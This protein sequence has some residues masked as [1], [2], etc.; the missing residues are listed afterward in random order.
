MAVKLE[1][2]GRAAFWR[3][4][5]LADAT[6][7]AYASR[8]ARL[9]RLVRERRARE[10]RRAACSPST[11]PTSAV[12]GPAGSSRRRRS[13]G[14][15][16]RCGSLLRFSLGPSHVP[17][18]PLAPRRGRRL[19]EAPK[20]A[21]VEALLDA[22]RRRR[23]ARPQEPRAVRARLLRRPSQRRGRRARS[24]RRRLRAGARA[25]TARQ[26]LEGAGR[27]ARRGGRVL[28]SPAISVRPARARPRRRARALPLVSREAARHLDAPPARASSTPPP[29]LVRHPSSGRRRRPAHDPG[30]ARA[31]VALDDADLQ[32]RSAKR[33]RRVY[34]RG[35]PALVIRAENVAAIPRSRRF[36]PCLRR[37]AR[38]GRSRPIGATS[39]LCAPSSGRPVSGAS[40]DELER[41]TAELRADGI[42]AATLARRIAAARSFFRHLQLLGARGGQPG[43]G[44]RTSPSH[45]EA[46]ADALGR[47]GRAADRGRERR[48]AARTARPRPGRAPLR[49]RAADLGG[50]GSREER[51]RPRRAHRARARQGEQGARRPGR[52]AGGRGDPPLSGSRPAAPRPQAPP[53]ALP[54]RQ[55]RRAHP[56]GRVPDPREA[57]PQR[58]GS[59]RRRV[60]PHLL[61]HSFATHLLEGGADL[62][63]VQEMLGHADLD[64]TELYTHVTDKRRR[65]AYF[66]AHPHARREG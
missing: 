35:S 54:E 47:R 49:L 46:S 10:D 40:V 1:R 39:R 38:P 34:D 25:R 45:P 30:A 7:R 8:P 12:R 4:P 13:R 51:R 21:D 23:R 28:G 20:A 52:A 66:A 17:E 61:R 33:L 32:P 53:R 15:S 18:T 9:R 2:G 43:R 63:S 11:R 6:R 16:R 22:V 3:R 58:R 44:A 31:R 57:W 48:L 65:D 5:A 56:L 50:R 26:R 24:R 64:T 37:G 19:P 29:P 60:H 14:G 41:Y 59:S 55:G 36:S 27:P 42:S 62:R